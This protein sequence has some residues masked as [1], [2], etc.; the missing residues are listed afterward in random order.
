MNLVDFSQWLHEKNELNQTLYAIVDP[1]SH[2]QPHVAFCQ[3]DGLDGGPLLSSSQLTNPQDGPWLLPVNTAFLD[4]W[5]QDDHAQSGII[6]ATAQE[7]D[8]VGAHFASLFQAIMLGEKVFFPF[9]KPSYIAEMLPR[10]QPEEITALL[11]KHSA[12]ILHDEQWQSWQSERV[13]HPEDFYQPQPEPWWVIKAHHLDNTPNLP[14]LANNVE[15]WLWV[16]QPELMQAR[17]EQNQANFKR[18]FQAHFSALESVSLA[19]EKP[20][21]VQEA[22]ITASIITTYGPDVLTQPLQDSIRSL[23]DDELL[24]GLKTVFSELQGQA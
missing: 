7:H 5:Q 1:Q 21:T 6:I 18:A 2:Y 22:T 9:Y 14:L 19:Q 10:L 23:K 17:I 4:W 13:V 15:A 8:E 3:C 11:L 20:L 16:H 12:L 24:F